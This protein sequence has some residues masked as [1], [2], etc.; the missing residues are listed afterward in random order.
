M[1]LK[2][3]FVSCGHGHEYVESFIYFHA[4]RRSKYENGL[5]N[6][7]SQ[8]DRQTIKQTDK[9]TAAGLDNLAA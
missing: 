8:T 9:Q 7:N 1:T 4:F 3:S 2:M 6:I 5:A